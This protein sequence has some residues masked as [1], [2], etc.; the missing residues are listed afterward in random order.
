MQKNPE[1]LT[2]FYACCGS[3]DVG[4]ISD[5]AVR[6]LHKDEAGIMSCLSGISGGVEKLLNLAKKADKNIVIDGCPTECAK[7]TFEKAGFSDIIHLKV[8]DLDMQK[9]KTEVCDENVQKVVEKIK[10]LI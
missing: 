5:L 6:K 3:A 9:F 8:S 10:T 1:K 4:E 2:L 7:K